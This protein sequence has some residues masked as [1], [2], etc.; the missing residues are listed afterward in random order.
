[1][2]LSFKNKNNL[3]S[4][5]LFY[6]IQSVILK[7]V[8]RN[9]WLS[10]ALAR[11]LYTL[12]LSIQSA[13][14]TENCLLRKGKDVYLNDVFKSTIYAQMNFNT[15]IETSPDFPESQLFEK[16][17]LY[18]NRPLF[19]PRIVRKHLLNFKHIMETSY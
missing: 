15:V 2:Q 19:Q 6:S 7:N 3:E 11:Y 8:Y 14:A 4:P 16:P 5:V 18:S 12:I 13:L 17:L 9:V 1:M 10:N